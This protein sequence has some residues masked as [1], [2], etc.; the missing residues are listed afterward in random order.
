MLA[1]QYWAHFQAGIFKVLT[2]EDLKVIAIKPVKQNLLV[3]RTSITCKENKRFYDARV[4]RISLVI[5]AR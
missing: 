1:K 4:V 3:N 2:L 5:V